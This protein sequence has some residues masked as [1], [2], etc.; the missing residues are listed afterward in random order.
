MFAVKAGGGVPGTDGGGLLVPPDID[1]R[2][3]RDLVAAAAQHD[4]PL[5]FPVFG[6]RLVHSGF[7]RHHTAAPPPAIG[8]DD[9]DRPGIL[10][11]VIDRLAGKATEHHR[12]DRTDPRAGEHGDGGFG[13]HRH[14]ND[15]AISGLDAVAL[16]H[17]G[18]PAD[19][20]VELAVG[21]GTLITGF[22]LPD[23]GGLVPK[24]PQRVAIHAVFADVELA[25]I[26]PLGKRH[27]PVEHRRPRLLPNEFTGLASP[28]RL[29]IGDRRIVAAL[30][31]CHR[32]NPRLGGKASGRRKHG[33][34]FRRDGIG[35]GGLAHVSRGSWWMDGLGGVGQS[36]P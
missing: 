12:V 18:K 16:E 20:A 26:E 10:Q 8:G 1:A 14:I 19:L 7:E 30:V 31:V 32:G 33:Q 2:L 25:P 15:H 5:D 11:A 36:F 28:E 3:H 29:G 21:Q 6:D 22:A 34:R 17:V 13:N 23:D 24:R 9:G 4:D 27:L 35:G